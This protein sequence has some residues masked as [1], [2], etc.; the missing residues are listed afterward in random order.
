MLNGLTVFAVELLG[1]EDVAQCAYVGMLELLPR[2]DDVYAALVDVAEADNALQIVDA[3]GLDVPRLVADRLTGERARL[4]VDVHLLVVQRHQ[5]VVVL[6]LNWQCCTNTTHT[7][8]HKH[9]YSLKREKEK[10]RK[11]TGSYE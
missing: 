5:V 3:V 2:L 1:A 7:H 8:T 9:I 10:G 6:D 11:E 4:V